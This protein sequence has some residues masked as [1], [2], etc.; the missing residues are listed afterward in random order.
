MQTP[1]FMKKEIMSGIAQLEDYDEQLYKVVGKTDDP[2]GATEKYLIATSEQ[3]MC[4]Y[5][6]GAWLEE[7]ELPK[8]CASEAPRALGARAVLTAHL[9]APLGTPACRRASARRRARR[10]RISA[11]SSASTSL[12]RSSSS[13]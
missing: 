10:A 4:G 9:A 2:E 1:F 8:K 7:A 12:R 5:H 11:V 6:Q 13:S 3:P